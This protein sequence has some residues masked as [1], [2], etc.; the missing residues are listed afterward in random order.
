MR[1][2]LLIGAIPACVALGA[3]TS[4][5]FAHEPVAVNLKEWDVGFK[6]M[7]VKNGQLRFEIQNA[8]TVEHAFEIEGESGVQEIEI[9]SRNLKPGEKTTVEVELAGGKYEVYCPLHD[10]KDKGMVGELTVGGM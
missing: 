7:E 8:G 3:L 10:H 9:K 6:E 2:Y 1:N 4:A 5:A